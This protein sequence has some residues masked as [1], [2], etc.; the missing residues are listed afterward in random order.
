MYANRVVRV[1]CIGAD[2]KRFNSHHLLHYRHFHGFVLPG[3]PHPGHCRN[4]VRR[5]PET[6]TRRRESR[7]HGKVG[8]LAVLVFVSTAL[9]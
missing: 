8:L 9:R 2:G 1:A 5:L 6:G 7:G 3:K 4:V